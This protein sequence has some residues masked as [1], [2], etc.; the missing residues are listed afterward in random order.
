MSLL[1]AIVLGVAVGF[2]LGGRPQHLM[3]VRLRWNGLIFLSMTIQL[4]LFTGLSVVGWLVTVAYLLSLLLGLAWLARNIR[5]AG[6]PCVMVGAL[7]N[8]LAI[9]LNGGRMPIEPALLARLRGAGYVRELAEARVTS[10]S[11]LADA[12][13]VLPWLTD[14]IVIPPPFPLPTVLSIGDLVI[15]AGVVWLIAAG[16]R[17]QPAKLAAPS[18]Q[19]A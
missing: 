14:W 8:A 10:N 6:I 5:V 15:A 1:S 17:R 13:T 4:L 3:A 7:S 18:T 2:A 9:A 16:M 19:A 12:H 11:S